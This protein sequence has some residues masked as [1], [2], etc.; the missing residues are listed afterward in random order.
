MPVDPKPPAEW[1]TARQI[2]E[3]LQRLKTEWTAG[4][5]AH[6][7]LV[8]LA[9]K[10]NPGALEGKDAGQVTD[11]ELGRI[12]LTALP[13]YINLAVPCGTP[14]TCRRC[15]ATLGTVIELKLG[16]DAV[17]ALHS[18]AIGWQDGGKAGRCLSC[19]SKVYF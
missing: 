12:I 2:V 3:D 1:V 19:G 13:Q 15:G 14:Y 10:C 7:E 16:G 4:M 5:S 17:R 9:L 11:T 18:T 6:L 8:T